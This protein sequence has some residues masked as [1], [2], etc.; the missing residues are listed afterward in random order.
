[1]TKVDKIKKNRSTDEQENDYFASIVKIIQE[2]N[3]IQTPNSSNMWETLQLFDNARKQDHILYNKLIDEFQKYRTSLGLKTSAKQFYEETLLP[4]LSLFR[5]VKTSQGQLSLIQISDAEDAFYRQQV[6]LIDV[7]CLQVMIQQNKKLIK[8][9]IVLSHEGLQEKWKKEKESD[10]FRRICNFELLKDMPLFY[11]VKV[12]KPFLNQQFNQQLESQKQIKYL[13]YIEFEVQT[14][15]KFQEFNSKKQL[16][17]IQTQ[18]T[19][20][21]QNESI[22]QVHNEYQ[23]EAKVQDTNI[24]C[25]SNVLELSFLVLNQIEENCQHSD[26]VNCEMQCRSENSSHYNSQEHNHCLQ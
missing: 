20:I 24:S 22:S 26:Y 3:L 1:M 8:K 2:N 6:K 14:L 17:T 11:L 5:Q 12:L 23:L 21:H 15:N 10:F 7:S 13:N 25:L 9:F 16:K 19:A 18:N 4:R